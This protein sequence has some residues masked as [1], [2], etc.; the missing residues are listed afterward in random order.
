MTLKVR[1]RIFLSFLIFSS[2]C[3][4][5]LIILFAYAAFKDGITPPENPIRAIDFFSNMRPFKYNFVASICAIAVFLLYTT[6]MAAILY[7]GISFY[8]RRRNTKT[9]RT[10][11]LRFMPQRLKCVIHLIHCDIR[12]LL[13]HQVSDIRALY[14][15]AFCNRTK[16]CYHRRFTQ[17]CHMLWSC[18]ITTTAKAFPAIS[19]ISNN[20][21]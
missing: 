1:N 21:D 17:F 20:A 18:I 12:N 5:S 11:I 3:F 7:F 8:T 16:Q 9:G 4:I 15:R 14:R 10:T 13:P 6:F 2:L 19:G